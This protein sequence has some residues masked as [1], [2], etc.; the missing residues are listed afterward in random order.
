MN[1]KRLGPHQKNA[2][3]FAR[4]YPGWHGYARD[5]LTTRVIASLVKRG[6]VESNEFQQFRA[7]P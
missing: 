6:L 7:I 2:L 4:K 5:P 3:E 1:E